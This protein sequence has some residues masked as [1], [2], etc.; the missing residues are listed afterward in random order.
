[1]AGGAAKPSLVAQGAAYN[2]VMSGWL[3]SL[4]LDG[5][6]GPR[7]EVKYDFPLPRLPQMRTTR[8]KAAEGR[9]GEEVF[10]SKARFRIMVLGLLVVWS[11]GPFDH[12][13]T[14]PSD[15]L[16][17]DDKRTFPGHSFFPFFYTGVCPGF[18]APCQGFITGSPGFF[19]S[20]ARVSGKG[21]R[22]QFRR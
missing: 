18:P 11:D 4:L 3:G 9:M 6:A 5:S 19:E 2:G 20:L 12:L 13:T 22:A 1:M 17:R 14:R 10:C 7:I 21:S 15:H 8:E 16:T